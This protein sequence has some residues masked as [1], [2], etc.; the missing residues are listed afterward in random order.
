MTFHS[1]FFLSCPCVEHFCFFGPYF[2]TRQCQSA[3]NRISLHAYCPN[4][5]RNSFTSSMDKLYYISFVFFLVC[6]ALSWCVDRAAFIHSKPVSEPNTMGVR[7]CVLRF[8]WCSAQAI[9]FHQNLNALRRLTNYVVILSI[10]MRF[11][12]SIR[13][14]LVWCVSTYLQ[15]QAF[16]RES[17][18]VET[19]VKIPRKNEGS[20]FS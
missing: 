8:C 17:M 18:L 13:H 7:K 10:L 9:V 14:T 20:P 4:A 3:C 19:I 1:I 5:I 2:R 12:Y 15:R 16:E 6:L 11:C